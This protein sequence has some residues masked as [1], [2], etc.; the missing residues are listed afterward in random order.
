MDKNLQKGCIWSC[1]KRELP[2][3]LWIDF[4]KSKLNNPRC[5]SIVYFRFHMENVWFNHRYSEILMDG[6]ANWYVMVAW[7]LQTS[8]MHKKEFF[9]QV[10][11]SGGESWIWNTHNES[12][13]QIQEQLSKLF[14]FKQKSIEWHYTFH[15][16]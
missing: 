11:N 1:I 15:I 3:I 16:C 8:W 13:I 4:F 9:R 7:D 14:Y 2:K 6:H 5:T 12:E 10:I